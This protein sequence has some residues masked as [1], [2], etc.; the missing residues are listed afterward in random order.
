MELINFL[1]K[2][3]YVWRYKRPLYKSSLQTKTI[4]NSSRLQVVLSK[5]AFLSAE[6]VGVTHYFLTMLDPTGYFVRTNFDLK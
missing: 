2:T 3:I 4:G 6:L 1:L 5:C